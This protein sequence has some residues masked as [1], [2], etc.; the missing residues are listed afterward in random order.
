MQSVNV[1]MTY[2][3]L[4]KKQ[5][6]LHLKMSAHKQK[7]QILDC[8]NHTQVHSKNHWIENDPIWVVLQPTAGTKMDEPNRGLFKPLACWVVH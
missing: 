3:F 5:Q 7:C 8:D 4:F 1:V 6:Q 2:S